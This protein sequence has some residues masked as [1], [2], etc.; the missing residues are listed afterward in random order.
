[1]RRKATQDRGGLPAPTSDMYLILFSFKS[2]FFNLMQRLGVETYSMFYLRGCSG[3][4][5]I[6]LRVLQL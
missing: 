1:M 6:V 4:T 5:I 2:I 3:Q